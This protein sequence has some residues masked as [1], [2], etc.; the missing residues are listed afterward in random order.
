MS[1][2]NAYLHL[3][4]L[5]GLGLRMERHCSNALALSSLLLGVPS[6]SA[7][8]YPSLESNPW[9]S[10]AIEYFQGHGG[11]LFTLRLGSKE[12]CFEFINRLKIAKTVAEYKP[13]IFNSYSF[14]YP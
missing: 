11:G 7:V 4:G 14:P 13:A 10:R 1:P 12:R 8:N 9:R 5:E 6:V 2:F 3:I